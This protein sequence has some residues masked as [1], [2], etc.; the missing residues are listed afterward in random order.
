M[1]FG[2]CCG[3]R[4]T[5]SSSRDAGGGAAEAAKEVEAATE[6]GV[7]RV[8]EA[9]MGAVTKTVIERVVETV[10]DSLWNQILY[11]CQSYVTQPSL[12]KA[13][14]PTAR[15]L[16]SIQSGYGLVLYRRIRD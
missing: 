2:G 6:V 16:Q 4:S 15:V 11:L 8:T 3:S 1:C 10:V 7:E 13:T 12:Q 14:R 5:G 9:V